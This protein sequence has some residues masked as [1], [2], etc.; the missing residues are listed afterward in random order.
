MNVALRFTHFRG[1]LQ[2]RARTMENSW[3]LFHLCKKSLSENAAGWKTGATEEMKRI[4]EE[5]KR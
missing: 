1:G 4:R 3:D 2:S 5:E